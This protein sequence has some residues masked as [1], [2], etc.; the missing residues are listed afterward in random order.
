MAETSVLLSGIEY[1]VGKLILEYEGLRKLCRELKAEND[2]LKITL[3]EQEETINR[4][5]KQESN[6]TII[7]S[8]GSEKESIEKSQKRIQQMIEEID[9][10]LE[11]LSR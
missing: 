11:M 2:Q 10:C 9:Q 4:I 3:K 7:Q 1:K 8:L 5:S 6:N